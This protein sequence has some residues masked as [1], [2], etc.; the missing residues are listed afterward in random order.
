[1]SERAAG[2]TS[3]PAPP[4]LSG[5]LPWLGHALEFRRDPVALLLQRAARGS[6]DVFSFRLAGTRV[7]ALTGPR[8]PG[9]VLPGARG[10]S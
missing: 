6:G 5:G 1:M 3:R 9:R 10:L 7:T 2:G 4:V 8:G